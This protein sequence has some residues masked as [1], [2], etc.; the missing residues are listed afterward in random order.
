MFL[1]IP[2]H[3]KKYFSENIHINNTESIFHIRPLSCKAICHIQ[4]LAVSL[5]E[6]YQVM[7]LVFHQ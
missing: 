2:E 6:V 7:Y 1:K 4:H 5:L 3:K